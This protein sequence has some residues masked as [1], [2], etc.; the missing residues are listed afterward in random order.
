MR[1][2]DIEPHE[3]EKTG[4]VLDYFLKGTLQG[5]RLRGTVRARTP[6]VLVEEVGMEPKFEMRAEADVTP[7]A[8]KGALAWRAP[9]VKRTS[10]YAAR[11]ALPDEC[12]LIHLPGEF[13][14]H[15]D[16]APALELNPNSACGH[17][18]LQY[19]LSQ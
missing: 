11:W 6:A 4:V 10:D 8:I 7:L 13:Q 5:R 14:G 12:E 3:C 17:G 18:G 1:I 2:V 15:A 9:A 19:I 16:A